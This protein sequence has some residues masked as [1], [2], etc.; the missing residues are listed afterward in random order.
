MAESESRNLSTG[1]L[2]YLTPNEAFS[3]KAIERASV[4]VT[5]I[6]PKQGANV[7]LIGGQ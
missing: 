7:E 1:Q 5:I 3:I 4:L 2:L 6:A